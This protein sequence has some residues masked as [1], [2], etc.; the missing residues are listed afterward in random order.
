M[1]EIQLA[2]YK[3]GYASDIFGAL[4]TAAIWFCFN[5]AIVATTVIYGSNITHKN[6]FYE[7]GVVWLIAIF[8]FIACCLIFHYYDNGYRYSNAQ[9]LLR[10]CMAMSCLGNLNTSESFPIVF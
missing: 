8:N 2:Y 3:C 1:E 10:A 7:Y 9:S 4:V 5:K 6:V